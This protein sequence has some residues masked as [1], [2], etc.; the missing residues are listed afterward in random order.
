VRKY[1]AMIGRS[2]S[3]ERKN[4]KEETSNLEDRGGSI[5]NFN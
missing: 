2:A 1:Y 4:I 3:K 5:L